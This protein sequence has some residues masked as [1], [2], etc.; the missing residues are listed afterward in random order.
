MFCDCF[1]NRNTLSA[2]AN[3]LPYSAIQR[4]TSNTTLFNRKTQSSIVFCS[5]ILLV[6]H[7]S[8]ERHYQQKLSMGFDRTSPDSISSV[9]NPLGS[10]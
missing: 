1:F 6:A 5:L 9:T 3:V 7:S 8:I 10:S 2:K 4:L